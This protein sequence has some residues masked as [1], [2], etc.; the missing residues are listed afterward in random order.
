MAHDNNGRIYI[1][2]SVTPN[3]GVSIADIQAVLGLSR[4]D[5]GGLITE[6]N[7]NM[8]S[9]VKPV[10]H[11]LPGYTTAAKFA[12]L[13]YGLNAN[14][15]SV[16]QIATGHDGFYWEYTKPTTWF[17]FLD[18][19]GYNHN[20]AGPDIYIH[21]TPIYVNQ[22]ASG[23]ITITFN[24]DASEIPI[25]GMSFKTTTQSGAPSVA[26]SNWHLVFIIYIDGRNPQLYNTAK[27]LS[28]F[29]VSNSVSIYGAALN[30]DQGKTATIVP[31]LAYPNSQMTEGLHEL[32]G[33]FMNMY[34]LVPLSFKPSEEAVRSVP[35]SYFE[36]FKG[37]SIGNSAILDPETGRNYYSFT[38]VGVIAT[39]I[40]SS[41]GKTF[42][43]KLQLILDRNGTEY[44]SLTTIE[45]TLTTT[46]T[47]PPY[48]WMF[49]P[50]SSGY[51]SFSPMFRLGDTSTY[52]TAQSGDVLKLRVT[53]YTQNASTELQS[54][55]KTIKT[56]Q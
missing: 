54:V 34:N 28:Q 1:D 19:D 37:M 10:E 14:V 42:L 21:A 32:S 4:N 47:V 40:D 39:G 26:L 55:T 6:G 25:L 3:V 50:G 7:I 33:S 36:W 49:T 45:E 38:S 24:A 11:N 18:F 46:A 2:T 51:I 20:A 5:I 31:A 35:I 52:T 43:F 44:S 9:A 8:W 12:E 17:R 30:S 23:T 22:S 48:A 29:M 56:I 16:G 41:I 15:K 27:S 13:N 53:A